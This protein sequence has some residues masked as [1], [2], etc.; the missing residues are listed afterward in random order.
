MRCHVLPGRWLTFFVLNTGGKALE[1]FHATF[2]QGMPERQFYEQYV[3]AVLE[4]FFRAPDREQ[5]ESRLPVYVP[6]LSGCR[7]TLERL[8]AAFQGVTLET[9]REDMLLAVIRGNAMYHGEHLREVATMVKL[10]RRVV[11]TGGAARIRGYT[12]AKRR[13][14]GDFDYEFQDESSVRGAAMLGRIYQQ[15]QG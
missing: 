11:T 3:P 12:D 8:T 1:W 15:G 10:G 14:T 13:W 6:F 2:C 5:M 7:Y 4:G 9:T